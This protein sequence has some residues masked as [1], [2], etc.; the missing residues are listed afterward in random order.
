LVEDKD[1]AMSIVDWAEQNRQ[2]QH[3]AKTAKVPA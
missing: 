1:G 3:E 2:K